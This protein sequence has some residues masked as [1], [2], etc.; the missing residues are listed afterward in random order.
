MQMVRLREEPLVP[1]ASVMKPDAYDE[2]L[3]R[4]SPAAQQLREM[5]RTMEL[6]P[7]QFRDLFSALSGIIGQPVFFYAGS[8]PAALK[9]QQLL[10]TQGDAVIKATLGALYATYQMNLDPL[11]QSTQALAQ[12]LSLP[13]KDIMPIYQI[14]RATQAEMDRIR[15]DETLNNDEKIQA[16]A[17]TRVQEQQTLEQLLGPDAF[18]RWLQTQ[19]QK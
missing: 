7:D 15:Q 8:D 1:L 12:Q 9:Q 10:A 11:Y 16:L 14:N 18:Q 2:F 17:Q 13:A 6:T 3:L 4:Y 19:G 5:M